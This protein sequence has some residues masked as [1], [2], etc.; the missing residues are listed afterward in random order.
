[1]VR[2]TQIQTFSALLFGYFPEKTLINPDPGNAKKTAGFFSRR[3]TTDTSGLM[4]LMKR[5]LYYPVL[6]PSRSIP[7][8]FLCLA[9][10][11]GGDG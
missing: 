11:S 9:V 8:V 6:G 10:S 7:A 5:Y 3:I 2:I 1:M 4:V